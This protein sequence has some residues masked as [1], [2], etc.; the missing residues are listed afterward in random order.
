MV[1]VC[2][3]KIDVKKCGNRHARVIVDDDSGMR[4]EVTEGYIQKGIVDI[5]E[6]SVVSRGERTAKAKRCMRRK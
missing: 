6:R 5:F 4:H 2:A 3:K 1:A